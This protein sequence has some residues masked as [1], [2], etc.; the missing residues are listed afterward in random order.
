MSVEVLR[1]CRGLAAHVAPI[2][3]AVSV[4]LQVS[5]VGAAAVEALHRFQR[6]VEIARGA[7]VVAVQVNG[8]WQVQFVTNL[9]QAVY[10]HRRRQL[11]VARNNFAHLLGVVAPLPRS[12][13]DVDRGLIDFPALRDGNEVYLC[14]ELGEDEITHWHELD[15]GYGGRTPL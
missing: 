14:W 11:V 9:G 15:D 6:G 7:E 1:H 5:H 2:V 3:T 13:E 4:V 8:M 12:D 10:D